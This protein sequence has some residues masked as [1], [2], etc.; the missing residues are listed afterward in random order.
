MKC[1]TALIRNKDKLD[2]SKGDP[3]LRT[4]VCAGSRVQSRDIVIGDN[5]RIIDR[6][7]KLSQVHC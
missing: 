1:A 7:K 3:D 4:L 6:L 5:L 2:W